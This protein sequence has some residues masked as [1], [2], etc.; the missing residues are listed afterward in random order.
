MHSSSAL[1]QNERHVSVARQ[2]EHRR[3]ENP[4]SVSDTSV[5]PIPA[6]TAQQTISAAS[7]TDDPRAALRRRWTGPL[8]VVLLVVAAWV[9]LA[10]TSRTDGGGWSFEWWGVY[11][12]VVLFA[13]TSALSGRFWPIK[14]VEGD[15]GRLSV[16][17][18]QI[19]IWTAA[20]A[21]SYVTLYAARALAAHD[22]RPID[23][24]PMNVLIVLGISAASAIGAKAITVNKIAS[25]QLHTTS[26]PDPASLGDLVAGNDNCPD[27]NKVQMLFWTLVSVA[28]YLSLTHGAIGHFFRGV[29]CSSAST[30]AAMTAIGTLATGLRDTN[31]L[32]LP[33][34]D[35]VL[36]VL[37]GLSHGTYLGGMLTQTDLPRITGVSPLSGPPGTTVVVQGMDFG[38]APGSLYLANVAY[39]GPVMTWDDEKIAFG[40]PANDATG[41]PWVTGTSVAITIVAG[42]QQAQGTASFTVTQ[43]V[44]TTALVAS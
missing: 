23:N 18:A 38:T 11:A 13:I 32:G 27:L 15:D 14:I 25:N 37:M 5:A 30:G 43:P 39:W 36:M 3:A 6:P 2:G 34:I 40:W 41:Q 31:C 26:K 20:V 19:A 12:V 22:L 17:K 16:S 1:S 7:R 9:L 8:I 42:G 4:P 28:V 44:A 10:H 35:P 29:D 33:N 21:Y 24:I